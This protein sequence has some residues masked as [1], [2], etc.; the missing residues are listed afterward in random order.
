MGLKVIILTIL[1]LNQHTTHAFLTPYHNNQRTSS[2]SISN[3]YPNNIITSPLKNVSQRKSIPFSATTV[4]A[5]DSQPLPSS[6][7][8]GDDSDSISSENVIVGAG[9][10]GLLSA[11][12]LAQ[13][14]PNQKVKVFDR[15]GEPP[16]PTDNE[17]WS[18]VA[19]FYLIGL[20]SRGQTA[21]KKYGVWDDVKAVSTSVLGRKDWS[22]DSKSD[23]GVERIFTDRPVMT[24]V[25]PREKLVGVLYKHILDN[26]SNTIELNYGYE[27]YPED[28]GGDHDTNGVLL[29]VSKCDDKVRERSRDSIL[30]GNESGTSEEQLCDIEESFQLKA[31]LLIAADGTSRTVANAMEKEDKIKLESLNMVQRMFASKPFEVTRY[32]DDNQRVY[33]TVPMVLPSGWRPDLNYSA[34]TKDGRINFDALPADKNG[35]YCGV[36][37]LRKDDELAQADTDPTALRALLDENLPQFSALLDDVT[38]ASIAKKPPSFLP[39]FRYA[40]PRLHQGAHTVILGD[41]AHTV[42][43]YFGLGAN[44][45]LEDVKVLDEVMLESSNMAQAVKKFSDKR[46]DESEALVKISRG[47]DRPGKLGFLTFVLPLILDSIFHG[48]APKI[49]A[50]NTIAMLQKEGIGFRGIRRRKMF[51]RIGQTFVLSS[52]LSGLSFGAQFGVKK[53]AK[54]TGKSSPTILVSFVA[55]SLLGSLLKNKLSLFNSDMA[56]ADVLNKTKSK[57]TDSDSFLTPLGMVGNKDE[58]LKDSNAVVS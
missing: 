9:P 51:D 27:I 18:D 38:V 55:L 30:S 32:V 29:R 8:N 16:S 35:N 20:G 39:S 17:I 11:I 34:R 46:A 36:L 37:L 40:G 2:S 26:Y 14:F 3:T 42:K 57:V 7:E 25:L 54:L 56:P 28:F 58:N 21:L 47:L 53:I 33:K 12:M 1:N 49:F 41:C 52:V 44:S 4:S 6:K 19:K 15:L 5:M 23:E 45:A 13:K 43:P 24:E 48:I 22:P 10:A 50:P 31:N